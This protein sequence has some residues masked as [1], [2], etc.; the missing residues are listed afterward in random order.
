VSIILGENI[1]MAREEAG[2][3]QADLAEAIDRSQAA[4]SQ[5][6]KGRNTPS[7]DTFQAIRTVLLPKLGEGRLNF[8]LPKSLAAA[9]ETSAKRVST[10]TGGAVVKVLGRVAA[11]QPIQPYEMEEP[12]NIPARMFSRSKKTFALQVQG[13]SMIGF[14]IFHGDIVI[15]HENPEP[16]NGQIVVARLNDYEYTLK[17]WHRDGQQITL[18]PA[19]P[20]F[21]EITLDLEEDEVSCVGEYAGLI[22][23]A[24]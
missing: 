4:L 24:K 18:S 21:D 8:Y 16:A 11:G 6:E 1:R 19:N 2:L 13:S 7:P 3:R 15:L 9:Q 20:D 10:R 17:T 22:R 12:I 23:F 5:F 14:G